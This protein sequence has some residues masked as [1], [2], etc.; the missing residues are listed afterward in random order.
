M[1]WIRH[2][3]GKHKYQVLVRYIDPEQSGTKRSD[4]SY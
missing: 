1:V 2:S 3:E 4:K